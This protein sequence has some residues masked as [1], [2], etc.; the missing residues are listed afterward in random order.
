MEDKA[1]NKLLIKLFCNRGK[2]KEKYAK[3][4]GKKIEI[5]C[6]RC[7]K[8]ISTFPDDFNTGY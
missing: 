1:I 6:G 3:F 4:T 8:K 7:V 5:Y 2:H